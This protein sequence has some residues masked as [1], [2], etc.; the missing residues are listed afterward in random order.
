MTE[1]FRILL[2]EDNAED[3][4]VMRRYLRQSGIKYDLL[5]VETVEAAM[6][7]LLDQPFDCVLL[8]YQLPDNDG[9]ELLKFIRSS[10]HS[11]TAVMLITGSGSEELAVDVM[12]SGAQDY[13]NKHTLSPLRLQKSISQAIQ[14]VRLQATVEQ[15]NLDLKN[16]AAELKRSNDSLNHFA[17]V[18]SHDMR[19]PLRMIISYLQLLELRYGEQF[20]SD[21]KEFIAYAADGAN[22]LNKFIDLLLLYSRVSTA[23][24][25][26]SI[27]NINKL[28]TMLLR[29]LDPLIQEAQ[30]DIEVGELPPIHGD[31]TLI[32]QLFQNLLTNAIKFKR[33]EKPRIIVNGKRSDNEAVY[34]V[35]DNGMGIRTEDFDHI[36]VM[37]KRLD[38]AQDVQ[39]TGIG[40]A[41][42]K[43]IVE[44]HDGRIW[45]ESTYGVGTTFYFALPH[46]A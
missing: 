27:V 3:I 29:D 19:Q 42:C 34:S 8:D 31:E 38:N 39:G 25:N 33:G 15:Q 41:T 23:K 10:I 37:F 22:R 45:F 2:V 9:I 24:L 43:S 5:L 11:P 14:T 12:K 32:W 46:P 40:L 17:Y 30:A 4:F 13:I 16:F 26:I 7:T 1:T 28:L 35:K 20:D 21:A 6:S 44:R 36:F 18:A